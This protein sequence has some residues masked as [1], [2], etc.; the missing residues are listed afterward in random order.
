MNLWDFKRWQFGF[1]RA[2]D[3]EL[4]FNRI[5][6]AA[7]ALLQSGNDSEARK[8]LLRA[9]ECKGKLQDPKCLEWILG[10]HSVTWE[11][12]E[13]YT[14]WS[15][16]FSQFIAEHPGHAFAYHLRGQAFWYGG[17]LQE[18]VADYSQAIELNPSDVSAFL[19][20]GQVLV[21][22]GD[23]DR[24]V[25]DLNRGLNDFSKVDGADQ[26]WKN[27]FEAFARNG[28]AAA[29]ARR[30]EFERALEEF[31]K[32]IA[33]APE[34]AWVYFN[35]AQAFYSHGDQAKAAEDFSLALAKKEPKLTSLKRVHAIGMLESIRT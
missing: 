35:R 25:E 1:N 14:E 7:I 23:F 13:E 33:L 3:D 4:E 31:E 30:G 10:W 9:L 6:E 15:K 20:R 12:T 24:S 19:G 29:Y 17:K 32:S 16:F 34:N 8:V 11:R 5:V 21:E 27:H 26:T 28:L 22:L 18:A 2:K